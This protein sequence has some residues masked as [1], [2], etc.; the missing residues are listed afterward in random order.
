MNPN[1]NAFLSQ[2]RVVLIIL[3]S[4]LAEQGMDHTIVYKYLL[5]AS[6]SVVVLGNALWA[7]WASY[8]NWRKASAVGVQAGIN[9]TASGQALSEA[10]EVISQFSSAA[11]TPPKP[12]T[13]ATAA[14]IVAN[15][16]P[17]PG[18]ISSK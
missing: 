17:N 10:G 3:G 7:L 14:E 8:S 9:L 1:L 4:L 11:A 12:V 2:L 16:G 6:G 5:V 18:E 13:V 15:F